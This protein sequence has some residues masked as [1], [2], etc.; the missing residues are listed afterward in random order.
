LGVI[1][2]YL[3]AQKEKKEKESPESVPLREQDQQAKL[4]EL[5]NDMEGFLSD[6]KA[7]GAQE[8]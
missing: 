6:V 4:S 1:I 7:G 2:K 5:E 8:K 3:I